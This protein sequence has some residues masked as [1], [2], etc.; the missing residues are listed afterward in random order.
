MTAQKSINSMSFEDALKELET[1]VKGLERGEAPL[2]D[3][4]SFYERGVALKEYCEKKLREAQ[5]KID[6]IIVG[7]DGSVKTEP[8]DR[9]SE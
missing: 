5:A 9:D 4:I 2:E 3:S 8:L 7:K 6:K 1:I